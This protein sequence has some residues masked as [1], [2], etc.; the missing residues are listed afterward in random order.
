MSSPDLEI[1]HV[2]AMV[3]QNKALA[4]SQWSQHAE[5]VVLSRDHIQIERAHHASAI[6]ML[7]ILPAC[8]QVEL[9]CLHQPWLSLHA[10]LVALIACNSGAEL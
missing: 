9:E 8:V 1:L 10:I 6:V 7:H 3:F 5:Q 4:Q 2:H